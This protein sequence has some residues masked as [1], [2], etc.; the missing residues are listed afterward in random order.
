MKVIFSLLV[1]IG[2]LLAAELDW[3]AD[4]KQALKTAQKEHKKVYLFITSD[5][6]RWCRKFERTTL[7]NEPIL[8]RLNKNYV[9]LHMSRDRD[10]VPS[11]FKT[12]PIPRHYFLTSKGD[13]IY[14]TLGHRDEEM[15]N[16]IL[17]VVDEKYE[18]K[19]QNK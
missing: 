14:D 6:C 17:D 2:T 12:S 10:D 4:Y 1:L 13:I 7:K 8:D 11:K 9:L 3:P 16:A 19:F 5:N 18:K 15:F